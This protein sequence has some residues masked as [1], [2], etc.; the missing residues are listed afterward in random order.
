MWT[1]Y[2]LALSFWIRPTDQSLPDPLP[3][4]IP[5]CDVD[6]CQMNKLGRSKYCHLHSCTFPGCPEYAR[7]GEGK[8]FCN[9]HKC[10]EPLCEAIRKRI[11]VKKELKWAKYCRNRMFPYWEILGINTNRPL[12]ECK[13]KDCEAK[14]V[15]DKDH[16]PSRTFIAAFVANSSQS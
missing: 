3:P 5:K 8:D 11:E 6:G 12:D 14:Q 16:C 15:S 2:V 13:T 7:P 9:G 1:S 10:P 4:P